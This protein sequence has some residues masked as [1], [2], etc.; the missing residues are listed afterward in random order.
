VVGPGQRIV[1]NLVGLHRQRAAD[2]LTH[3]QL[4]IRM[5]PMRVGDSDKVQRVIAQ[6]PSAGQVVPAGSS[7]TVLV[8]TRRPTA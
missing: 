6:Q 1:P 2:V 7:V 4:G 5:V 3:V 8:G